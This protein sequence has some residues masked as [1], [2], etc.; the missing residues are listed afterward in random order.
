MKWKPEFE[1]K[2]TKQYTTEEKLENNRRYA[3]KLQ[4]KND[5]LR[6]IIDQQAAEIERLRAALKPF[7][8]AYSLH[9]DRGKWYNAL[10]AISE[11]H[12]R[13]AVRLLEQE[14]VKE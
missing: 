2:P 6:G 3:F 12:L 1:L 9:S 5:E 7:A 10:D 13:T 8:D 11:E 4:E 14:A